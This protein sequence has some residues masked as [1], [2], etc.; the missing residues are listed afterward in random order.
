MHTSSGSRSKRMPRAYALR[1]AVVLVASGALGTFYG[2]ASDS[3]FLNVGV[4]VV[5]ED[6]EAPAQF[7]PTTPADAA[8]DGP[9]GDAGATVPMCISTD[10]P[11][12]WMTCVGSDGT[13]PTYA[14]T[15]DLSADL[16]N[17]GG[18]GVECATPNPSFNLTA[19]CVDAKCKYECAAGAFDCN[20]IPDDGCEAQP[21]TDPLNCGT[22]GNKCADGVRCINGICGCPLGFTDC[23]GNCI[24]LSSNDYN[25]GA[26]NFSCQDQP[27]QPLP[28]G[29]AIPPH[30]YLGCMEG[31]C[32]DLRC[33][34]DQNSKWEDCNDSKVPDGCE[35]DL[36][37]GDTA[38]CGK[39]GNACAPGKLCFST[40]ST[41]MACQCQDGLTYCG[42]PFGWPPPSCVDTESDPSNCG[43]CGYRCPTAPGANAICT[44]GRCGFE[45]P[46]G[47]A[48]CNGDSTDGC[49][50]D[51][52]AD[53]RHCGGCGTSCDVGK[54]QPCADGK[55]ATQECDAGVPR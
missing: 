9:G 41:G 30:M 6:A 11:W 34:R 7:I 33:S 48:D 4:G 32:Q 18:C 53:P 36:L 23:N 49:E 1:V 42:S 13:L 10:C 19:A 51:L 22:C 21:T 47:R 25:C 50:V 52:K 38:N 27:P 39:C 29:G 40:P 26:C 24:D 3:P 20:G 28:D 5:D 8:V 35:V 14:C 44:H 12:P 46:E 54:G 17:C 31:K 43:G 2:C 16:L 55:C 15:T 37:S 45:C